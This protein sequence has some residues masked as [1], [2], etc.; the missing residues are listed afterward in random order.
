MSNIHFEQLYAKC[1]EGNASSGERKE[2]LAWL[3][4]PENETQAKEWLLAVI[5]TNDQSMTFRDDTMDSMLQ[6]IFHAEETAP[7]VP[8]RR[9]K[10][11]LP[12]A[13]AVVLMAGAAWWFNKPATQ[14]NRQ[15]VAV[16]KEI[17]PARQ[18][19]ILT[20]ANGQKLVLDSL[21]NGVIAVQNGASILLQNG[22]LRYGA[23]ADSTIALNTITTPRGRK[24]DIL[25]GDGTHI[26]LNAA[27]SVTYPTAFTG[28]TRNIKITGEAY[29]EVAKDKQKPFIV[30][31]D[32][33]TTVEV[34]GTTFN[35][36]AYEDEA[37][38]Q[39]TLLEG[40]IKTHDHILKPG[41]Q[42]VLSTA[43]TINDNTDTDQVIAWKN[44][45][46][47]FKQADIRTVMREL[48]RWY[49]IEVKY[50]GPIPARKFEGEIGRDLTLSQLLKGLKELE[51]HFQIQGKKILVTQ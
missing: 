43:F 17:L 10:S 40:S 39:T 36:K 6:A 45:I 26:W 3:A 19:A 48:A 12:Y 13:A 20:L 18:G 16:Q 22:Q 32:G 4:L 7:V 29:L 51:I 44:G 14:N 34:L 11:W 46:F 38:V 25:L 42:A 41:Q 47:H 30:D 37:S 27:S 50:S 9:K 49:D 8:M 24:F 28:K 35:I 2:L 15:P 5:E 31:V 1:L 33:R 23:G 21:N